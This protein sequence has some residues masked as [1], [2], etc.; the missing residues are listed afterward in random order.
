M[1]WYENKTEKPLLNPNDKSWSKCLIL[2]P[3]EPTWSPWMHLDPSLDF[4]TCS[5][6]LYSY[7]FAYFPLNQLKP[8]IFQGVS[9]DFNFLA[10]TALFFTNKSPTGV[11]L[12]RRIFQ[13]FLLGLFWTSGSCIEKKSPAGLLTC[14]S[15]VPCLCTLYARFVKAL[16]KNQLR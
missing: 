6:S 5:L 2:Y 9:W 4:K 13:H 14:S 1:K 7:Y 10:K 11:T 12:P 16:I 15:P 8:Y 3:P